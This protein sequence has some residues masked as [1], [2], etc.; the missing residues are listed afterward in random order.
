MYTYLGDGSPESTFTTRTNDKGDYHMLYVKTEGT[1]EHDAVLEFYSAK[2]NSEYVC[3]VDL[4][5]ETEGPD[6]I[7]T[8]DKK[9]FTFDF[10]GGK[11]PEDKLP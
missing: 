3:T 8:N 2:F 7:F 6:F 10:N 9:L 4:G 11:L 1:R 5:G